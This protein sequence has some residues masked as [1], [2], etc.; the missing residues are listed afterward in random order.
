[1]KEDVLDELVSL[2]A[3]RERYGVV[4][5]GSLDD[6]DLAIDHQATEQLRKEMAAA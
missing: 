6:Y 1:M 2:D 3:A 5:T 4:L